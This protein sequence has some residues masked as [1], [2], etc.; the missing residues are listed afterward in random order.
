MV[1]DVSGG[2]AML[3]LL[4]EDH[5]LNRKLFRDILEMQFEVAEAG[6]AEEA[7]KQLQTI[8]PALILMDVQLPGMDGITYVRELKADPRTAEI[9]VV[10]VSAHAMQRDIE[11]A[12][13]AGCVSYITK[14]ITDDP[15]VFLDR[16]R[17]LA[18]S[19]TS[20]PSSV[21]RRP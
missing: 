10:A 21:S 1:G 12:H 5:P 2:K 15:F 18:S 14:P 16:L 13:A 9:P 8:T 19:Q 11:A 7:R 20:D 6:S 3:V 17:N 4:V